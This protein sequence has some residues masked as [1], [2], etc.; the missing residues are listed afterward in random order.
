MA[1]N[2][3]DVIIIGSGPAGMAAAIYAQRA[4]LDFVVLEEQYI[5]GGQI[6]NTYD[7]DNYPGMPNISGMELANRMEEHAKGLGVQVTQGRVE[8]I[9]DLGDCKKVRTSQEEYMTRTVVIATGAR[10]A[11]LGVAGEQE[12]SGKGVSYCATCDGAFFKKRVVCVVGGGDVAAEDAIFL[13]RLCEKVYLIH[14]RDQ[15][16]AAA[17][18][19]ERVDALPN[20]EILWNTV[21][22]R[23]EG[24]ETVERAA[25]YNKKEDRRS[26]LEVNGVFIA[27]GIRPNSEPF[28]GLVKTDQNGYICA[29]ET[30]RTDIPGVFAAGDVRTKQLRQ[31]LTA[32]SDGANVVTSVQQYLLT[33]QTSVI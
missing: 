30:G 28:G 5:S 13:S 8:E 16:R 10:H 1:K 32:A 20:V 6:I 17:V 19:A 14:R 12:F 31:I 26:V 9:A 18:L 24:G 7:V 2:I 23:I 21:V 3:Y 29:D 15:L 27:V 33:S 25:L 22:E 4:R 11:Q